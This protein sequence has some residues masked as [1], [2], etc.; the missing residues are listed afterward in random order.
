MVHF[1]KNLEVQ[2]YLKDQMA[3]VER[4]RENNLLKKQHDADDI[5][6][7]VCA[8]KLQQK[9]NKLTKR[10]QITTTQNHNKLEM[11]VK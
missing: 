9:Q 6:Q 10:D 2:S 7:K 4:L 1:R 11:A 3:H 5:K 8:F